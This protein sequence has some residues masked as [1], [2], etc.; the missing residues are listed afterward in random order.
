MFKNQGCGAEFADLFLV[1]GR[2]GGELL[3]G[4]AET[5]GEYTVY[6]VVVARKRRR[7]GRMSYSTSSSVI[8]G[9]ICGAPVSK[10]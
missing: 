5:Y 9:T 8:A 7:R 1:R 3:E 2:D 6:S 4:T 10:R